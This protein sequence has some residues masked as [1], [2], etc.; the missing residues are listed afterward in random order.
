MI[1]IEMIETRSLKRLLKSFHENYS[2]CLKKTTWHNVCTIPQY[3]YGM[4][5]H[6]KRSLFH[7]EA[8]DE[9]IFYK[10]QYWIILNNITKN[11]KNE[12]HTL[13]IP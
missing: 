13:V 3:P 1:Y 12:H 4:H 10:C 2:T 6:I 8:T 11:V 9:A 5:L 7:C